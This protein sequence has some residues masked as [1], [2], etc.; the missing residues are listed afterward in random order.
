[1]DSAMASTPFLTIAIP[2]YNRAAALD[3][4]LSIVVPQLDDRSRLVV[5]DN[6]S[7]DGTAAVCDRYVRTNAPIEII[8]NR[9]NIGANA[10]IMRCC[11]QVG[12][13]HLWIL[14]DDD[15]PHADAV[16]TIREAIAR[17]P[18]AGY[19]NFHTTILDHSQVTRDREISVADPLG[20]AL[21]LDCFGN[22]L[23]LP[24]GVYSGE[25]VAAH[26]ADGYAAIHTSGPSVAMV[27]GAV[28]RGETSVVFTPASICA[29]GS[30][31]T[32]D[33]AE[34][35]QNVYGLIH[36]LP[37]GRPRRV[38]A[39][40][41]LAPFPPKLRR[42]TNLAAIIEDVAAGGDAIDRAIRRYRIAAGIRPIY[43]LPLVFAWLARAAAP[44]GM[45]AAVRAL[46]RWGAGH[47]DISA[48]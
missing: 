43:A 9:F 27:L 11:E 28:A 38:F 37:A 44:F 19:L 7:T 22:L 6:A 8:R 26:I 14:P 5:I 39:K 33:V 3:N 16:R 42:R 17:H 29:W 32:W 2:T 20:F 45:R 21:A 41:L 25:C 46:R 47:E 30:P 34:V 23:F 31:P 13:G 12:E 10:N 1:M 24:A 35:T 48:T 36:L 4:T 15:L 18:R 40:K